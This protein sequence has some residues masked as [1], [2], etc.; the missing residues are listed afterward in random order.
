MSL[1]ATSDKHRPL[2]R[3]G[4]S[5]EEQGKQ[6]R[7]RPGLRWGEVSQTAMLCL[8]SHPK[9]VP[10]KQARPEEGGQIA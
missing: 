1:G 10:R 4:T 5:N 6:E 8:R 3:G 7:P 9:S 2:P